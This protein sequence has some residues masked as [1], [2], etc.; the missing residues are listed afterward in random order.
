M[1]PR[2]RLLLVED[3]AVSRTF[4]TAVLEAAGHAVDGASSAAAALD[5]ARA[6]DA[7]HDLLLIDAHL[8]DGDGCSLLASLRA[9][10][11]HAPALAHTAE[12]ATDL[13]ERLREA[14]FD[15]VLLKPLPGAALLAA[16]RA[17]L[18]RATHDA[19]ELWDDSAATRALGGAASQV[20][21]LRAL[22]VGELPAMAAEVSSAL[23]N[24][25]RVA[26]S[27][28]LHR[29][30]ASCGFVGAARIAAAVQ[31]LRD[32]ADVDA[33]AEFEAAVAATLAEVRTSVVT[34]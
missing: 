4:F 27:G 25:D 31:V 30:Q 21:V 17:R 20:P 33:L 5:L 1:K 13:H 10:G 16:V 7:P 3:D 6:T 23:R 19:P 28:I 14:G 15:A 11:A 32:S 18:H 12:H 29:L 9:A 24:E 22:F 34:G 2:H 8:P 26:A